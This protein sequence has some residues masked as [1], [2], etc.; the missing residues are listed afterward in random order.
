MLESSC[1]WNNLL[2]NHFEGSSASTFYVIETKW[3]HVLQKNYRTDD[4]IIPQE[5]QVSN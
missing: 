5:H 2:P 3:I 4:D 1:L